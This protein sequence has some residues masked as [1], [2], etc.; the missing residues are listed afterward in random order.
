MPEDPGLPPFPLSTVSSCAR[1]VALHLPSLQP[2]D[3]RL[4][5]VRTCRCS[6]RP[7]R[8]LTFEA[9]EEQSVVRVACAVDG[10]VARKAARQ[11]GWNFRRE[12]FHF[13][14]WSNEEL[15]M[16]EY[17]EGVAHSFAIQD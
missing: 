13:E 15:G 16:I 12:G 1:P 14:I 5:I 4:R 9:P 8:T 3:P 10:D 11:A 6:E 2:Q 17:S 7:I